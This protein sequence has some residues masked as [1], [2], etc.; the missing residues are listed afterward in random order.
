MAVRL[1]G[2]LGAAVLA[3]AV[4]ALTTAVALAR[5]LPPGEDSWLGK[6]P[7]A[8]PQGGPVP[9]RISI[10]RDTDPNDA[11]LNWEHEFENTGYQV[12]RGKKPYFDPWAGEGGQIAYRSAEA[13]GQPCSFA[14]SDDGVDRYPADGTLPEVQVIG[15]P[16]TNY[17]WVVRGENADGPSANS[18]RV[19]E[20]DFALMA[21]D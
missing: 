5:L 12:W 9:P 19:G 13:C 7:A 21:G 14:V 16:A 4:L 2:I 18:N 3:F 15:D 6:S 1:T 20:F 10:A 8:G 17:F 11:V